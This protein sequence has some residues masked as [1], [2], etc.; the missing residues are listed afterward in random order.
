MPV[1]TRK[2]KFPHIEWLDLKGDG[3]MHECAIMKRDEHGNIYYFEL[4]KCDGIDK[5]R[6]ARLVRNRNAE[7]FELWDLMSQTTLNNG[8]N[9]LTYFHQ[10]VKIISPDGVIY[11]PKGG[12]VGMDTRA[13]TFQDAAPSIADNKPASAPVESD[14]A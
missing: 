2:G 11:S 8:V 1:R 9:A 7:N 5:Q 10:L 4:G 6:V 13:G 12:V 14:L 3:L